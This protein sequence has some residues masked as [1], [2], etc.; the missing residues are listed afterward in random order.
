MA[1]MERGQTRPDGKDGILKFVLLLDIK[2]LRHRA[3]LEMK[4]HT[5]SM[6]V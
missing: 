4:K 6:S 2:P 1:F 5:L 3:F